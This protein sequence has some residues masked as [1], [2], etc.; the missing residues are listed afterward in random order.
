MAWEVEQKYRVDGG[1]LEAKLSELGVQFSPAV[2][3]CD[4]Y[5]NHPARDFAVTDEALRIRQ[6]QERNFVTYKGPKVDP[7]SKTRR[8]IELPLGDGAAV[9]ARFAE[10]LGALGFRAAGTVRKTRQTG[11]IVWQRQQVEVALD[12]VEGLGSFLELE[13]TVEDDG[14]EA[15][16]SA[17]KTLAERLGLSLPE[18]RSYLELL[19]SGSS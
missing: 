5:F 19:L 4:H 12:Q 16:R 2:L 13:I 17:L 9:A 6:V 14:L 18:R 11:E 3:Q 15:A 7:H 10:V 1:G 8:E